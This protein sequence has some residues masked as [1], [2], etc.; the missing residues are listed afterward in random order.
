MSST[1]VSIPFAGSARG[2]NLLNRSIAMNILRTHPIA[3]M[4]ASYVKTHSSCDRSNFYVSF[5]RGPR[6]PSKPDRG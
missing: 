4:A 5:L 2:A 1:P 3:I 6:K